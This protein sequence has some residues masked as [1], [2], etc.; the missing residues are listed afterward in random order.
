MNKPYA[1]LIGGIIL[2]GVGMILA[3]GPITEYWRTKHVTNVTSS[4]F[5][6]VASTVPVLSK[7]AAAISG[8]PTRIQIPA[9]DID[10]SIVEGH[11][12]QKSKTWTI[13]NDKV[14]FATITAE[15]NNKEGNTF[16]YGHNRKGVFST[17]NKIHAGDEAIV[18]TDNGHTFTY[19]FQAAFETI[20]SD[21]TLFDYKGAPI[22]TIQ[23]CSGVWYQNRQLFTFNLVEA[24]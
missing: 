5:S 14:Q 20:P 19:T 21:N 6:V 15:P 3:I 8:K 24:K 13:T 18:T 1:W 17:L 2:L 10:L 4:P 9:L 12:N 22:L 11:Y 16:L 23:T 7:P